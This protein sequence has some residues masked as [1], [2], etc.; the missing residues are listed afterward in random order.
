MLDHWFEFNQLATHTA[1]HVARLAVL[2]PLAH[3]Q[4]SSDPDTQLIG[5]KK[6]L[7]MWRHMISTMVKD[8]WK[9][10]QDIEKILKNCHPTMAIIPSCQDTKTCKQVDICPWCYARRVTE[11]YKLIQSSRTCDECL[12]A[13]YGSKYEPYNNSFSL[14]QLLKRHK[15]DLSDLCKINQ[16]KC[17]GLV[18]SLACEPSM[19]LQFTSHWHFIYRI[20][21]L[22]RINEKFKWV[23][24]TWIKLEKPRPTAEEVCE[25][26]GKV[27]RYPTG[28]LL[29]P[30]KYVRDILCARKSL[31]MFECYGSFRQEKKKESTRGRKNKLKLYTEAD[32]DIKSA[33]SA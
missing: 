17:N 24:N 14:Q 5:L 25:V 10:W 33:D 13:Y 18:W 7:V 26:I 4:G 1:D 27:F 32:G 16:E 9:P 30:H 19:S 15:K 8:D 31:R 2:W 6:I 22:V 12:I 23:P 3:L 29:G 21:A 28:L 20:S 11:L